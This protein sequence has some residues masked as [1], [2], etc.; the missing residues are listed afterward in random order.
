MLL[1]YVSHTFGLPFI[2][3]TMRQ[4]VLLSLW[5][6]IAHPGQAQEFPKGFSLP[7]ELGQG[8]NQPAGSSPLYLLTLQAVP[9]VT[10]IPEHLRLGAVV[11]GFYPGGRVGGLAGPRLALK[12]LQGPPILSASSYNLHLLA[13][14]LWATAPVEGRQL[15]GGGIGLGSSDLLAVSLKV[16]RDLVQPSTWFQFGM[17]YNPAKRK[18]PPL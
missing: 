8:F 6:W 5:L 7:I 9:Q 15:L 11:G 14:F 17:S 10:I 3:S 1:V 18:I 16:H 12:V 4:L 13:E 2:P